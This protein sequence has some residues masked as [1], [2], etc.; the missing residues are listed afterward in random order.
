MSAGGFGKAGFEEA[1][2]RAYGKGLIG[3]AAYESLMSQPR[4]DR[5]LEASCNGW[6]S[7]RA[8]GEIICRAAEAWR[9]RLSGKGGGD[10]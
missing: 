6:I 9:E 3:G 10:G 7:N 2:R 4:L 8:A 5:V 1:I